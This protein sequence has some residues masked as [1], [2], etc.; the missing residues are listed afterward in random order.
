MSRSRN[1]NVSG[2]ARIR[3]RETNRKYWISDPTIYRS[4]L[5]EIRI[6]MV[7]ASRIRGRNRM[8]RTSNEVSIFYCAL[9]GKFLAW[10]SVPKKGSLRTR[11]AFFQLRGSQRWME[12]SKQNFTFTLKRP[13]MTDFHVK[14]S[15]MMM[16]VKIKLPNGGQ[17][18]KTVPLGISVRLGP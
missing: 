6:Y 9:F 17:S 3:S 11:G 2:S 7:P 10:F 5:N 1:V 16:K 8:N 18:P 12:A 13:K 15:I 14:W 4:Q